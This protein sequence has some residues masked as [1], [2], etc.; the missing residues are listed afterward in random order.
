MSGSPYQ[1]DKQSSGR[2]KECVSSAQWRNSAQ[3]GK[4]FTLNKI[5]G[6]K[7]QTTIARE[8]VSLEE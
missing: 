5:E 8:G 2:S 6:N 7:V 4:A 1:G 3:L